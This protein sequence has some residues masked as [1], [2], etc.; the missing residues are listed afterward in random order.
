MKPAIAELQSDETWDPAFDAVAAAPENHLILYEDE[1][2]RVLYV[3]LLPGAPEP[4]HHHQWPSVFVLHHVEP[5]KDFD[6]EGRE[7][8][9]PQAIL[10]AVVEGARPIVLRMSPQALHSVENVGLRSIRG[11]RIEYK[12][13][14]ALA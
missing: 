12:R 4:L 8:A 6:R 5:I 11:F 13:Q 7:Q 3:T 2:V 1:D 10:D 14:A 9:P